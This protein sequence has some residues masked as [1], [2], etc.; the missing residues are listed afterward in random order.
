MTYF[1][2]NILYFYHIH[3]RTYDKEKIGAASVSLVEQIQDVKSHKKSSKLVFDVFISY[4]HRNVTKAKV[5]LEQLKQVNPDLKIFFDYEELKTGNF[6]FLGRYIYFY[7]H[8]PTFINYQLN[9]HIT[10]TITVIIMIWINLLSLLLKP[11]GD[12]FGHIYLQTEFSNQ[13]NLSV[14]LDI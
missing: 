14:I 11:P 4:S 13:M 2:L 3:C 12:V 6:N 1:I 8:L 5:L 10:V 9:V 7:L